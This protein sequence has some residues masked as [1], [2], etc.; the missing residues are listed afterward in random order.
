VGRG[1][2]VRREPVYA[3]RRRRRQR[4]LS[5]ADAIA[6]AA[7]EIRQRRMCGNGQPGWR[8]RLGGDEKGVGCALHEPVHVCRRRRRHRQLTAADAVATAAGTLRQRHKCVDGQ[9][10]WG[11]RVGGDEGRG[12]CVPHEHVHLCRRRRRQRQLTAANAITAAAVDLRQRRKCGNGQ[13]GW[14]ERVGGDGGRGGCVPHEP[15]H[16]CRRPVRQRQLTAADAMAAVAVAYQTTPH[17]RRWS[18]GA[19]RAGERA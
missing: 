7:G 8:E 6:E 16:V 9:P 3:S 19:S 10:G 13:L 1:G 15:V 4:K 12:G 18:T 2:C 5:A 11:E 14:R 17:V